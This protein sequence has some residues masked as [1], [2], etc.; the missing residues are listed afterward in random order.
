VINRPANFS[1]DGPRGPGEDRAPR[2]ELLWEAAERSEQDDREF[3]RRA[4]E[5]G[6]PEKEVEAGLL[7]ESEFRR[8]NPDRNFL[9]YVRGLIDEESGGGHG[10]AAL[11][12][13]AKMLASASA[14]AAD[15]EQTAMNSPASI[16]EALAR[17]YIQENF[18]AS[19]WL[20]VVIRNRE[21]G[22]TIQRITTA[23]KI[24]SREF[25][26]WLRHQNAHGS[27]IYLS[28]NTFRE[29]AHG[30]TKG[31]LKE[32][33]HVYLDLDADGR[34][35][36]A[37]IRNDATVPPPNYVLNTSPEKYQV[38]WKM[39]G[40]EPKAAESLLRALA[41]RFG[42]DA[43]ATDSTRVFRLPGFNNK[44]YEPNFLITFRAE[45][46][47]DHVYGRSDFQLES[48]SPNL[49][50]VA[51]GSRLAGQ[52]AARPGGSQSE[53]D[54]S[55]ALRRLK[56]GDDPENII[57]RMAAFRSQDRYDAGSPRHLVAKSKTNPRYY[58][59]HT[60]RR[61]MNHLGMAASESHEVP[62][63]PRSISPEVGPSR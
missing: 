16:S 44:K 31:D 24:A 48:S 47:P 58:A 27:D 37:A 29:R 63:R 33:R 53:R 12:P 4:L 15:L 10:L 36:L 40:I 34:R 43:A 39:A 56:R 19:D 59:E 41:Q 51:A 8:L 2:G 6:T 3:I 17:Q 23:E 50:P 25:Q 49:A 45:A 62:P 35:K 13:S 11:E 26:S 28:L 18:S 22:E 52:A 38:I 21:T 14:D 61:A 30:R 60:V 1:R 55:Y 20:A 9:A 57:R 5:R 46:P 7:R 42:A 32:I 54:W